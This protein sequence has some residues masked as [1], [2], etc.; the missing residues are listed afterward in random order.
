MAWRIAVVV[1]AIFC[2][3]IAFLAVVQFAATIAPIYL[4]KNTPREIF[5]AALEGMNHGRNFVAALDQ[6][7]AALLA[8]NTIILVW[9]VWRRT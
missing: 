4:P 2:L 9:L 1:W 6:A 5:L 7:A 8:V 3:G